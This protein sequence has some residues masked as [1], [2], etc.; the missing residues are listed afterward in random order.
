[1][2][3][4]QTHRRGDGLVRRQ[5]NHAR[6]H[7]RLCRSA[8]R[9]AQPFRVGLFPHGRAGKLRRQGGPEDDGAGTRGLTEALRKKTFPVKSKIGKRN[10]AGGAKKRLEPLDKREKDVQNTQPRLTGSKQR[11]D[12]MRLFFNPFKE[13]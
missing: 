9:R 7:G 1:M 6:R 11:V 5:R 4:E 2:G 3:G 8:L 10:G 13:E 12:S